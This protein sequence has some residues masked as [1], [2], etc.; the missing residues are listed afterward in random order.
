M[1]KK[2]LISIF[3]VFIAFQTYAQPF[4]DLINLSFYKSEPT[5]FFKDDDNAFY[6]NSFSVSTTLPLELDSNN[7]ISFNPYADR[8]HFRLRTESESTR[9]MGLGMPVFFIHQWK[10]P[11]W[12]TSAGIIFRNNHKNEPAWNK[13]SFQY[14]G[15]LL[16]T[17]GKKESFKIKF[18]VYVNT[19]FYGLYV[20]PLLGIDWRADRK[21]NIFGVLP[22]NMNIEYKLHKSVHTGISFKGSITSYRVEDEFFYR[23]DDNYIKLY[24]DLYMT[25]QLVLFGEYG[26]SVLRRVRSGKRINHKTKYLSD[27]TANGYFF[28]L[29]FAYRLRLDDK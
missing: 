11:A 13:K 26:H 9:Y 27:D 4:V 17:Y 15:V 18:G 7:I 23:I 6:S 5:S 25:K 8:H 16:N 20:T 21:L 22:G 12:K 29:G 28:R 1:N 14:G 2:I 19:E 3:I 24:A 10:N